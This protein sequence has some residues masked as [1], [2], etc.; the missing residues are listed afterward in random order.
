MLKKAFLTLAL[1]FFTNTAFSACGDVIID[2]VAQD[3]GHQ[4]Q[5]EGTTLVYR[6]NFNFAGAGVSVAD[7][8]GKTVATI[9]AGG[10]SITWGD[11][12][13]YS[14][15]T[16]SVDYNTTNLKITLDKLNTIQDIATSSSPVFAGLGIGITPVT[17]LDIDTGSNT[18]GIRIRGLA[19]TVEIADIY[20]GATVQ[21]ILST[22]AGTGTSAYIDLQPEDDQYGLIVRE[23]NGAGTNWAN[24]YVVDA[25]DD[26]LTIN[27]NSATDGDALVITASDRVAIG[28]LTP[29]SK[30]NVQTN[31][32][33]VT[34]TD[35]S[36]ILLRNVTA[37]A[38]NAQQISPSIR[39]RG[40]GWKTTAT[41]ASQ[42]VDFREY[43]LP[44]Q[45][46]ANPSGKL[47]WESS[48]N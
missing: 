45:G 43:V 8:G 1:L 39:W 15:P 27:V 12:L 21:L 46:A 19:E 10:D 32:L 7:S 16:A 2:G 24:F 48:I 25:A 30:L 47:V 31:S 11:G 42:S 37:A 17:P 38:L 20:V 22:K 33:G 44:V 6:E 34:Q 28:T 9:P 4:I 36:G 3:C 5:D 13:A 40:Q 29:A 41:A 14:S 26:Y 18:A 35:T 23:G